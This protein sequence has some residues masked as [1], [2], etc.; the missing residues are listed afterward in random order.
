MPPSPA[1]ATVKAMKK[2]IPTGR[3]AVEMAKWMSFD[4]RRQAN[5]WRTTHFRVPGLKRGYWPFFVGDNVVCVD[6]LFRGQMGQVKRVDYKSGEVVVEGVNVKKE[7]RAEFVGDE[8]VE[9]LVEEEKGLNAMAVRLVDPQDQKPCDVFFTKDGE[10]FSQRSKLPL[11][12]PEKVSADPVYPPADQ[13]V[14]PF[15]TFPYIA[16]EKTFSITDP[17]QSPFP[18]SLTRLR[19]DQ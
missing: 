13:E 16:Q 19:D 1:E 2:V 18:L 4:G 5:Q 17:W 10:R 15:D 14:G 8:E 9:K 6:G 3:R 11:P 7:M 12:I